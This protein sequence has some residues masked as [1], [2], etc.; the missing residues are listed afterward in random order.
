MLQHDPTGKTGPKRPLPD[1]VTVLE[2]KEEDSVPVP[3]SEQKENLGPAIPSG[4][5]P[6]N[7]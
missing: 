5:A 3:S 1:N 7:A 6:V 4:G 2:P